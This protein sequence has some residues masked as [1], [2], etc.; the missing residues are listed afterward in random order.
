MLRSRVFVLRVGV[1]FRIIFF[2]K[3]LIKR[4]L[5]LAL[6]LLLASCEGKIKLFDQSFGLIYEKEGHYWLNNGQKIGFQEHVFDR[7]VLAYEE[8]HRLG[9]DY[10]CHYYDY[11]CRCGYKMSYDRLQFAKTEDGMSL[12]GYE[13]MTTGYD[14]NGHIITQERTIDKLYEIPSKYAG[15]D[16]TCIEENAFNL[17]EKTASTPPSSQAILPNTIET[18]KS[19]AFYQTG[20]KFIAKQN[21]P[22]LVRIEDRAFEESLFNEIEIGGRLEYLGEMAFYGSS[23]QKVS[24]SQAKIDKISDSCFYGCSYL[25]EIALPTTL[26]AIEANAFTDCKNL[27]RIDIP[28]GTTYIGDASFAGW[29]QSSLLILPSSIT[30][31]TYRPFVHHS[32]DKYV[33]PPKILYKGEEGTGDFDSEIESY[34]Y[35][36][37]E[38]TPT[39]AGKYWH[40]VDGEPVIYK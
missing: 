33:Y 7:L 18:I 38:E 21:L 24:L 40:Y 28:E 19:H 27:E 14:I 10:V 4:L 22:N 12:S 5:P 31:L 11:A 32:L 17:E 8:T 30:K 29:S 15:E 35:Y 37:S 26:Q 36:Y 6:P 2:M 39:K 13:E 1:L 16:V 3:N 9:T 34:V 20:V 25:K 23:I